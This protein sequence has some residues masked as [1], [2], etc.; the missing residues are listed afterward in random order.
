MALVCG[1]YVIMLVQVESFFEF[2]LNTSANKFF[3]LLFNFEMQ[4]KNEINKCEIVFYEISNH[5]N[6][7]ESSIKLAINKYSIS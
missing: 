2:S 3:I 4:L 1:V 7:L 6:I 5:K